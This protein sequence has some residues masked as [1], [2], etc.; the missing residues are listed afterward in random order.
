MT[1][2]CAKRT[3]GVDGSTPAVLDAVNKVL[4]LQIRRSAIYG[5]VDIH[6]PRGEA[7]TATRRGTGVRMRTTAFGQR[8]I[9]EAAVRKVARQR[10]A[11]TAV[12]AFGLS[13]PIGVL[14]LV[15]GLTVPGAAITGLFIGPLFGLLPAFLIGGFV[16]LRYMSRWKKELREVNRVA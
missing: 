5:A 14:V 11:T 12:I 2:I 1:S 15:M 10:G 6:R 4:D 8:A 16:Q 7:I 3:V 13:I 9:E